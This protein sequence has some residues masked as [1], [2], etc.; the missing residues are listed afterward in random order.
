VS[1]P[2]SARVYHVWPEQPPPQQPPQQP[3]P[4]PPLTLFVFGDAHFSYANMCAD[5]CDASTRCSTIVEFVR[6]A[7][8]LA[9]RR[10]ATLDV[11][12]E[13]LY[14]TDKAPRR[15][16][17]TLD[18]FARF[19]QHGNRLANGDVVEA[20]VIGMLYGEFRD[21]VYDDE[22]KR[23]RR[24]RSRT[25]APAG[26][27]RA[28]DGG[29]GATGGGGGGGGGGSVVRFHYGDARSE[30]HVRALGLGTGVLR[31]AELQM[32]RHVFGAGGGPRS[33]AV[34]SVLRAMLFER[35]FPA[36]LSGALG[37][38]VARELLVPSVLA[39]GTTHRIAKQFLG[40]GEGGS[41]DALRRYAEDRI[42]EAVVALRDDADFDAEAE[43]SRARVRSVEAVMGSIVRPLVMDFYLLCRLVRLCLQG[44]ARPGAPG[45]DGAAAIVYVG[46]QHAQ[47]YAAFMRDYL[48]VAPHSEQTMRAPDDGLSA[49]DPSQPSRCVSIASTAHAV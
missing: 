29:G 27:T 36:A 2:V 31:V 32:L 1:G 5:R 47:N 14:V 42:A 34:A 8:A 33:Q 20:G 3:Q 23:R 13:L 17:H 9:R 4:Q 26:Q 7:V 46:E 41:K 43:D 15:R 18:A 28:R 6:S 25:V 10:G 21:D 24:G 38:E 37:P 12:I 49:H 16:K 40:V 11:F 35:D 19:A 30:P 22:Y 45:G 48:R 39:G 44:R